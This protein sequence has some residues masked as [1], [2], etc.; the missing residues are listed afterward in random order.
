MKIRPFKE[1]I[2]GIRPVME[3]LDAGQTLNKVLLQKGVRG[4]LFNEMLEALKAANAPFQFVPVE[5]LN[6][7]TRK[8]HQGV[9]CFVS[10]VAYHRVEDL[11]PS[12]YEEGRDP[13][14][15]VLDRIT[16]VR[17]FG[18]IARTAECAGVDA[19][20]I[21]D[22]GGVSVTGDAMKTSAGAL[23][24]IPVCREENIK[25]VLA[26]LQESGIQLVGCTEKTDQ[27]IYDIDYTRPTAIIMGS[28][29]DGISPEFMKR[30]DE[31]AKIPMAG[32]IGS[33]NVAVSS[34]VILYELVRQRG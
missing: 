21:P 2:F 14:F 34:G 7:V 11:L 3:A 9:V 15:L 22:K 26:Y 31:L 16:D 10:P 17:N 6:K 1:I 30:C 18:A 24:K 29:E 27:L 25:S 20:I 33:L 8:N 13:L 12:I 19:I 23:M 32:E 5:R 4:E 28:E